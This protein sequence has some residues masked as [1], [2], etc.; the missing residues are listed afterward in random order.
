VRA[1]SSSIR[2]ELRRAERERRGVNRRY[3]ARQLGL[4]AKLSR[5]LQRFAEGIE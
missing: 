5:I 3:V 2:R 4:L 1:I